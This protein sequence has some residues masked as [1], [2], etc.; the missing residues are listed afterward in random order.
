MAGVA[1]T[2]LFSGRNPITYSSSNPLT[3]FLVQAFIIIVLCRAIQVPLSYLRQPRVIGEIVGG[4]LLGKTAMGRIPN[5]TNA[6]FPAASMPNLNLV[7]NIGLIF[8][9]FIVGMEI[10]IPYLKKHWKIAASVGIGSIVVPFALGIAV[11]AGLYNHFHNDLSHQSFGVFGLFI[12]IAISITALP[13]LARILS[14]LGILHETSGIVVLAAGV[15]NDIVAWVLLALVISLSHS[16]A[17]INTLYI[18]LVAIGWFLF[19]AFVGRPILYWYLK[20]KGSIERGPS[21]LDITVIILCIFA[22]SFFTDII[23]VHQIFGA[24]L[25]GTII[26]R[27]NSFPAKVT[28]KIEDV[29]SAVF[30]PIYFA[31]SGLNVDLT[32]LNDGVTWGYAILVIVVSFVGKVV[33]AAIPAKLLGLHTHYAVESGFLMSCKGLVELVVLNIGLETGILSTKIFSMFVLMAIVTTFATTP[34][35][36]WWRNHVEKVRMRTCQTDLVIHPNQPGAPRADYYIKKGVE[37]KLSKVVMAFDTDDVLPSNMILTQM[38]ASPV[39]LVTVDKSNATKEDNELSVFNSHT[40]LNQNYISAATRKDLFISAVHMVELTERTAD[41]IQAISS[42][43]VPGDSDPVMKILS[44][45]TRINHIPFE[46][47]MS[48]SP[49]IERPRIINSLSFNPSDLVF[50]AW[51]DFKKDSTEHPRLFEKSTHSFSLREGLSKVESKV[52]LFSR[53]FMESVSNVCAFIDRGFSEPRTPN[54]SVNNN[55]IFSGFGHTR[56]VIVPF[57]GDSDDDWLALGIA[58]YMARNENVFVHVIVV[59][60]EQDKKKEQTIKPE[61]PTNVSGTENATS[62]KPRKYSFGLNAVAGQVREFREFREA[63]KEAKK[64][65]IASNSNSNSESAIAEDTLKVLPNGVNFSNN[66]S[67][68]STPKKR[69]IDPALSDT[70]WGIV[71]KAYEKIPQ[72]VKNNVSINKLAYTPSN[73]LLENGTEDDAVETNS[74]RR[75]D[76]DQLINTIGLYQLQPQDLVLISR[77]TND[78]SNCAKVVSSANRSNINRAHEPMIRSESHTNDHENRMHHLE[79]GNVNVNQRP[80][81]RRT[82]SSMTSHSAYNSNHNDICLFG[83]ATTELVTNSDLNC[84]FMVCQS[85]QSRI[86]QVMDGEYYMQSSARPGANVDNGQEKEMSGHDPKSVPV[87]VEECISTTVTR[88]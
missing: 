78:T 16:G 67:G 15:T 18:I 83:E 54:S 47:V 43:F 76:I 52:S 88:N 42:D 3:L 70:T 24:F 5:F 82:F 65:A 31:T 8:F 7:A 45:F 62:S 14:E 37:F 2:S 10:D 38:L 9:L 79:G 32:A 28:E 61:E 39:Q 12:G 64:A 19:L 21:E 58:L 17:P 75:A 27:D 85:L 84:S 26:P 86:E 34:F 73:T 30:M 41:L 59:P 20:R 11:A 4:I 49:Q 48:I 51:D 72:P 55:E 81:T 22:S 87:V 57:F 50:V 13:V 29:M 74:S 66:A 80:T 60:T 6:I 33:G 36:L 1:E 69:V 35:T 53:L 71:C 40:T 68:S 56:R 25:I 23:G 77:L 46:G 63:S 44:T